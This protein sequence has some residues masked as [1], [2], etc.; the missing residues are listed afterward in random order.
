[1]ALSQQGSDH[2]AVGVVGIRDQQTPHGGEPC[3]FEKHVSE[4][5]Q[6]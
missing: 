4:L 2:G 3:D 6:L 5:G 1:M